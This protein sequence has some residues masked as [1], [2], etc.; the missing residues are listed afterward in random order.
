MG[1]GNRCVGDQRGVIWMSVLGRRDCGTLGC[2]VGS[3]GERSS[4]QMIRGWEAD[5][6]EELWML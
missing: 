5:G 4:R 2:L 6:L 3:L 1:V